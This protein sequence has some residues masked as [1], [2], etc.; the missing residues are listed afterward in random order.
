MY[1][2]LLKNIG[3][4]LDFSSFERV[5]VELPLALVQVLLWQQSFVQDNVDVVVGA[6]RQ[7]FVC[8]LPRT[9]AMH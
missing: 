2:I 6:H 3:Q 1:R 9:C 8:V 5:P 4:I 7:V